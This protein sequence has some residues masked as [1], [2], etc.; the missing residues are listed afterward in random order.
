M[1]KKFI[2]LCLV[3]ILPLLASAEK[4]WNNG[5]Y[6]EININDRTAEVIQ[7]GTKYTGHI[8]IPTIITY[9][10]TDYS[11]IGIGEKAFYNCSGVTSI[12]IPSSITYIKENAFYNCSG[13]T[14][15]HISSIAKWCN[16]DF[17][18]NTN[19]PL[20]YAKNL[21]LN[22][23]LVE[24]M[25]IPAE[26]EKIEYAA[27]FNCTCLKSVT[28]ENGVKNIVGFTFMNCSSL[29]SIVIPNSI[30]N[31]GVAT[32]ANCPNLTSIDMP[33]GITNI[34]Q[35]TFQNCTSLVSIE[36]PRDIKQIG[37]GAF[38]G[39]NKLS[40]VYC[41]SKE[42]PST[43]SEAFKNSN[44]KS[45]RLHVPSLSI[46]LYSSISPWNQFGTILELPKYTISFIV[47]DNV[48]QAESIEYGTNIEVPEVPAKEGYSFSGWGEVPKT[49]PAKDV[50]IK[51]VFI[52]NKY[53]L[54]FKIGDEIIS[55][56]SLKY[57]TSVVA[58]DV[59][60]KE[61]YTFSGW[62]EVPETM[63]AN[64][65]VIEGTFIANK[66]LVTFKV[67]DEVIAANTLEYDAAI[68]APEAPEKEGHTFN[69]WG[70]VAETVPAHDVTYEGSYSINS[71]TLAYV[72]DGEAVL[73]L[74]VLYGGSIPSLKVPAKEG[75]TFSGWSVI[76]NAMPAEDVTIEGAF[77]RLPSVSLTINQAD[78]GYVK[79][80]LTEGT[81]CTFTIVAAEGWKIHSVTFNGEEVTDQITADSIFTTPALSEEAVLNIAYEKIEDD[82]M[83]E[84]ARASR[85]KVQGHRGTLRITG[86][87][88]GDDISIYTT[89]G[90]MV[91]HQQGEAD[92]NLFTVETNK[93]YIVKIADKVVKIGM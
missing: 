31:I 27:F 59:F 10:A 82:T 78:N 26:T 45:A 7:P 71:Y 43:D 86:T 92:E 68:V 24:D 14:A 70:D 63:P 34:A 21:Y 23:R 88:E 40:D 3:M 66:Y 91:A 11:V 55:S 12:I 42:I 58:P 13:L 2:N 93:V 72:V 89:D 32:F 22:G 84:N 18:A 28:I 5:V 76:P 41:L 6:Y 80:Q 69:G 37:W 64:D 77:T 54:T 29:E 52:P 50:T 62:S 44:F 51:G 85:I 1:I 20:Y 73:T 53:L 15:V 61:G 65:V 39:C 79:Q 47:D 60:E 35:N 67:G 17:H 74:P 30:T 4:V 25:V 16:I 9:N 33:D 49:M 48:Y 56:D 46:G 8:T 38:L 36:I 57:G 83:V 75:Y 19:N 90:A 87:T 81:V